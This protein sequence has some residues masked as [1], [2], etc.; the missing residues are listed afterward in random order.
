M[1]VK[2]E[3]QA[4]SASCPVIQAEAESSGVYKINIKAQQDRTKSVGVTYPEG[5]S[6]SP[7]LDFAV[8]EGNS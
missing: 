1:G 2:R 4:L 3:L 6:C 5:R 7:L 8:K